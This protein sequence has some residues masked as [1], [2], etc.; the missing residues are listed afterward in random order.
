MAKFDVVNIPAKHVNDIWFMIEP[1]I[2]EAITEDNERYTVD[3]IKDLAVIDRWQTWVAW[4]IEK[5]IVKVVAFTEL[6]NELSGL[7]VASIRFLY[8]RDRKEWLDLL[9]VLEER[10]AGADVQM[11]EVW[12]RRGWLRELP[13]Y[14]M[15]HVLLEKDLTNAKVSKNIRDDPRSNGLSRFDST[16]KSNKTVKHERTDRSVRTV[17]RTTIREHKFTTPIDQ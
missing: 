11:M 9:P 3:A 8:G 17:D 15:T 2:I 7:R 14:K 12:A 1:L 16:A 4:D 10:M 13:Q 6:Y 5:K